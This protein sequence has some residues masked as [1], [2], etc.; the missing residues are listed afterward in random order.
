[1]C[2]YNVE[3]IQSFTDAVQIYRGLLER[4]DEENVDARPTYDDSDSVDS[5]PTIA[6]SMRR[7]LSHFKKTDNDSHSRL[8]SLIAS[9]ASS[10]A[11]LGALYRHMAENSSGGG[12]KSSAIER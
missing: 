3:S 5:D 10:L 7:L 6:R 4:C 2:G 1:M 11:N 8:A 9:Y 12:G